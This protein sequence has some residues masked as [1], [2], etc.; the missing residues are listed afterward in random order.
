MLLVKIH[1]RPPPVTIGGT[2]SRQSAAGRD[3]PVMLSAAKHLSAHRDRPFAS[4]RVTIEEAESAFGGEY[5]GRI[6]SSMGI[7]APQGRG[8]GPHASH[9]Q[10]ISKTCLGENLDTL[11]QVCY[12]KVGYFF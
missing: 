8:G 12:I 11:P 1:Y 3:S 6:H 10:A 5:D 7:I 9:K 2:L 4:L